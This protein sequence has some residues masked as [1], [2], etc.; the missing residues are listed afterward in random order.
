MRYL[1]SNSFN[2]CSFDHDIDVQA[3]TMDGTSTNFSAMKK[4]GCQLNGGMN[5]MSGKFNYK[6]MAIYAC[7]KFRKEK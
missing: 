6:V 7:N 2:D 5:Q 4:F 3:C 1:L